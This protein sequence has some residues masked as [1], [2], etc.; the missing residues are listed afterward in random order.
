MRESVPPQAAW[1]VADEGWGRRATDGLPLRA[2]I[3]LVGYLA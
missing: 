2:E 3:A 1:T